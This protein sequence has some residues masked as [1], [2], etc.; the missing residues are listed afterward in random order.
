M[1]TSSGSMGSDFGFGT[2]GCSYDDGGYIALV[3]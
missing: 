3:Y 1:I 2:S